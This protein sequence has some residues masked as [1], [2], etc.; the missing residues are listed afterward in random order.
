MDTYAITITAMKVTLQECTFRS[1]FPDTPQVSITIGYATDV[2]LK[3][4]VFYDLDIL[5]INEE[6]TMSNEH[7]L[8]SSNLN[9][10]LES[11]A[12]NRSRSD[13][14]VLTLILIMDAT[15]AVLN[16]CTFAYANQHNTRIFYA[17]NTVM[18]GCMLTRSQLVITDAEYAI[19]EDYTFEDTYPY[20]ILI[21]ESRTVIL[22]KLRIFGQEDNWE[23]TDD[24][25]ILL[26]DCQVQSATV[27]IARCNTTIA[28]ESVFTTTA[29]YW[30]NSAPLQYRV[31][32]Q[33]RIT[34]ISTE[35]CF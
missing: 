35:P 2:L 30:A 6:D 15:C 3:D 19:L 8:E 22:S 14:A 28:G 21:A 31:T 23:L 16:G 24:T 9:A 20:K 17:N 26:K 34:T 5:S 4:C 1:H 13:T 12:F 11:C 25:N 33:S 18:E 7:T 29:I 27:S 32:S 10:M